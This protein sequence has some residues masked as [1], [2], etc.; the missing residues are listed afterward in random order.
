[1]AGH[2]DPSPMLSSAKLLSPQK[3]PGGGKREP[4]LGLRSSDSSGFYFAFLSR[5]EAKG[6]RKGQA[7]GE[8][9]APEINPHQ[10]LNR[11]EPHRRGSGGGGRGRNNK[12]EGV[13]RIP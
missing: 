2:P 3:G 4:S 12:V 11:A 9:G 6:R 1:M 13:V 8:E 5:E 7:G 10:A